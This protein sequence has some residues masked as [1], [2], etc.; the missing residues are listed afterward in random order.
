MQWHSV[1]VCVFVC[2][3]VCVCYVI[4]EG[5]GQLGYTLKNTPFNHIS[6]NRPY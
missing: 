4:K 5:W 1:V 2:V 3:F 6:L